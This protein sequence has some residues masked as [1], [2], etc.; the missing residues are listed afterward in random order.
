MSGVCFRLPEKANV[1][2]AN[3]KTAHSYANGIFKIEIQNRNQAKQIF[4][5][6]QKIKGI[7]QIIRMKNTIDSSEPEE[8][9]NG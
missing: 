8:N 6:I 4:R 7:K 3:L 5:R 9:V 2:E 1:V